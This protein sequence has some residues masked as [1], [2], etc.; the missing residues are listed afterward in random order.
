VIQSLTVGE[1]GAQP[2]DPSPAPS[3]T[4][5]ATPTAAGS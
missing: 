5:S 2:T 4:P 3:A 1:V